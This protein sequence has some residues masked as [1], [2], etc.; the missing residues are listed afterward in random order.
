[1]AKPKLPALPFIRSSLSQG[2]G[3][4][5]TYRQYAATVKANDWRGMRAQDFY[6]LYH[7][8]NNVRATVKETMS[9]PP[10]TIPSQIAK[11]GTITARGYGQWVGIHQRTRGEN[12]YIFTPFLVKTGKPIT[13]AEAEARA[14]DWLEQ[15]PDEYNRVTLAVGYLTTEQFIPGYRYDE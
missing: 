5:D 9:S 15:Q 12:D 4:T 7:E 13:P 3:P 8:T 6:R 1:M 10:N 11:R 14:L 2:L